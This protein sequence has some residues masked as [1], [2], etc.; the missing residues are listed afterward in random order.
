MIGQENNIGTLEKGL[1]VPLIVNHN[2]SDLVIPLQYLH[3]KWKCISMERLAEEGSSFIHIG[4]NLETVHLS[5]NRRMDKKG[6][7][8]HT[9]EYYSAKNIDSLSHV[10]EFQDMLSQR[11]FVTEYRVYTLGVLLIGNCRIGKTSLDR[12][13]R[14]V[15]FFNWNLVNIQY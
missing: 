13:I 9:V 12:K 4:Q 7:C 6:W 14:M 1:V 15:L 10:N 8:I 11:S 2:L 5:I 3:E